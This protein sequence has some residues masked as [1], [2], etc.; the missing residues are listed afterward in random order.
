MNHVELFVRVTPNASRDEITGVIQISDDVKRLALKVRA[1]PENG[2][3]NKAAIKLL[4]KQLQI[5]KSS[6]RVVK[7]ANARHKTLRINEY[8]D[9]TILSLAKLLEI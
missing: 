2:K 6:I 3:A 8:S 7:G 1:V 9:L 4:A 5:P